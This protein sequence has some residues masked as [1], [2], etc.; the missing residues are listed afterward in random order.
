MKRE[1]IIEAINQKF[2]EMST[3]TIM[4]HQAVADALGLHITDH[5]SY[6]LI[7]RFGLCQLAGLVN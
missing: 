1:E 7:S 3:E 5:K 4:F 6:D 2:R